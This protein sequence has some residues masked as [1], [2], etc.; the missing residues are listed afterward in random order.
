ML[1]LVIVRQLDEAAP[2]VIH[3]V[4][5]VPYGIVAE[6]WVSAKVDEYK[7]AMVAKLPEF[8]KAHFYGELKEVKPK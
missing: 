7:A 5:M 2:V 4:V 6:N 3:E 1:V 8:N